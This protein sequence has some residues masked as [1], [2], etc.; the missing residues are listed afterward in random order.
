MQKEF[1][2]LSPQQQQVI[3][4][5]TSSSTKRHLVLE[6]PAGTGKTLV[7][8]QVANNLLESAKDTHGVGDPLLV[9]SAAG[10]DEDTPIMK[11]LDASTDIRD[12]KMFKN[13]WDIHRGSLELN[14]RFP[15]NRPFDRGHG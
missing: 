14:L 1:V 11:Y 13:W 9:V 5:F 7:A 12:N 10:K 6:G 8:L 3:C 15:S 2:V 4:N